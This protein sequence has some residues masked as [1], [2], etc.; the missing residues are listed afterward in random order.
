[1]KSKLKKLTTYIIAVLL[2]LSAGL[3][4]YMITGYRSDFPEYSTYNTEERGIKALYLLTGKMGFARGR[5]HYPAIFLEEETTMV[6]YRPGLYVFNQ[7]SEKEGLKEWILKGNIL[8]LIPDKADLEQLW[9]FDTI[10][11][12]K[13]DH[14]MICIG[15]ITINI[16]ELTQGAIYVM[17]NSQSFF[18][19][20]IG[21][22][23]ASVAF[24]RVLEHINPGRVVFNEYYHYL[25]KSAPGIL[26]LAGLPG[27]LILI[28]LLLA[29]LMVVIRGW[30]PFGRVRNESTLNS[31]P[32]NEVIKAL[33]GLYIRMRASS[34]V[35]SNYYCYF[36]NK[37][38][39]FLN[40][41]GALQ[42]ESKSVL[43]ECRDFIE[44]AGRK[45][46]DLFRLVNKLQKLEEKINSS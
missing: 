39:S 46:K 41:P 27:Q 25:Q 18:N 1:M 8:I 44:H 15:D 12:L 24:I 10:S 19:S 29:A 6:A 22:S 9:I 17:D 36:M 40:T 20:D 14:E 45:K 5:Y 35:L 26:V 42:D 32:E 21:S 13:Q 30:K 33:S 37:Y 38:G 31:R 23:D 11:E 7:E 16:Y 34:L 43:H 4:M 3:F 28:Q 2:F